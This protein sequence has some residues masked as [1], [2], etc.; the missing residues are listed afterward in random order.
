MKAH[1]IVVMVLAALVCLVALG[2][3][4][5]PGWLGDLLL[6][7]F[8]FLLA[9]APFVVMVFFLGVVTWLVA[10]RGRPW[11]SAWWRPMLVCVAMVLLTIGLLLLRV[12]MRIAFLVSRPAFERVAAEVERSGG[13]SVPR[14]VGLYRVDRCHVDAR[15]GVYFRVYAGLTG[16][17]PDIGSH[18]FCRNPNSK[19][20]PFGSAQYTVGRFAGGWHVFYASNDW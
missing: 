6:F 1:H 10:T 5:Y 19:G 7:A 17:G 20:P 12:P 8:I 14:R 15:G 11:R 4:I 2:I 16:I 13:F 9:L 18:G 3:S